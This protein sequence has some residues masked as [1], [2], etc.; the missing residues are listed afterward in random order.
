[1]LPLAGCRQELLL[2]NR[3]TFPKLSS[4]N[5]TSRTADRGHSSDDHLAV[6]SLR[7]IL[8]QVFVRL[9]FDLN[10]LLAR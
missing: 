6:F 8:R 10:V 3:K 9:C 2:R 4:G 5:G 7:E 1:M